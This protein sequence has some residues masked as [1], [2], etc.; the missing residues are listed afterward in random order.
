MSGEAKGL[1]ATTL[2]GLAACCEPIYA[3]V[4]ARKNR[5]FDSGQSNSTN[6]GVPVI[7]V[8][9]LTVGGT[10]KTPMVVWLAKWFRQQGSE[11]TI[12]SRG[13]GAKRGKPNDEY[14]EIAA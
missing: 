13:Y 2:R 7:S 11:V 1:A 10:G 14:Q 5:R 4:V 3:A 9:N 8:G 12:I 6:V